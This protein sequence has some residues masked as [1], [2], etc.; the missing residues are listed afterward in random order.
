MEA[1]SL[2]HGMTDEEA[3]TGKEDRRSHASCPPPQ[4]PASSRQRATSVGKSVQ[5]HTH[6]HAAKWMAAIDLS[7]VTSSLKPGRGSGKTKG[8]RMIGPR[9]S[10]ALSLIRCSSDSPR[11]LQR[12]T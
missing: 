7:D 11:R 3:A 10:A 1:Q 2:Q 9:P 4:P 5:K 8:G 6:M 12:I